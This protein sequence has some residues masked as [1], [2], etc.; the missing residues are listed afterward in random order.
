[1]R[2]LP[3]V[4]ALLWLTVRWAAGEYTG[5]DFE[6]GRTAGVMA[7]LLIILVVLFGGLISRYKKPF[8]KAPTFMEDVR[9]GAGAAMKYVIGVTAAMALWY[10]TVSPEL[11]MRRD[12]DH[13][14]NAAL[15]DTPEKLEK[16][17]QEYEQLKTLS[18]EEILAAANERTDLMTSPGFIVSSS[19]IGLL[20]TALLYS[21]LGAFIFRQF[22]R[23]E[24]AQ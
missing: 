1:M 13:A 23:R 6:K 24:P 18:A 19:F 21:F 4:F 2:W 22:I 16:V 11:P 15:V 10:F 20:F 3:W 17:R 12:H 14:A 8:T 5:Y 9:T 7:N